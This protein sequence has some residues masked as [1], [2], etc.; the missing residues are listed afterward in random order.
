M[1]GSEGRIAAA[2][3]GGL[4]AAGGVVLWARQCH[5]VATVDG[6]SMEPTLRSGDRLL[7]RRTSRVRVGQIVVVRIQPLQLD[8]PP[9]DHEPIAAEAAFSPVHPDGQLFVKRAI[10]VSGDPVPTDRVP[11]LSEAPEATVPPGAL[12]VLGDN[13]AKSWDSRDYGFVR[14]DQLVGVALRRLPVG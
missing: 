3:A 7:V 2:L 14:G 6:P 10:A 13:A 12:V 11:L 1:T 5:L 4:L 8:A 9:P